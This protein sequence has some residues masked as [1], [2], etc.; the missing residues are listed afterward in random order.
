LLLQLRPEPPSSSSTTPAFLRSQANGSR[1]WSRRPDPAAGGP[2]A[3]SSSAPGRSPRTSILPRS[4]PRG[5]YSATEVDKCL[6]NEALPGSSRPRP[7]KRRQ[8]CQPAPRAS[9][10]GE[11][12][13]ARTPGR[14]SSPSTRP[15]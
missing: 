1:R 8:A 4:W 11:C 9:H 2:A 12:L 15:A 5:D 3:R 13:P 10:H 6:A 7:P 14:H